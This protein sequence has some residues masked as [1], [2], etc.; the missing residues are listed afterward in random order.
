L[1]VKAIVIVVVASLALTA[2]CTVAEQATS[3]YPTSERTIGNTANPA[4][5]FIAVPTSTVTKPPPSAP[6]A[7]P[8]T[9]VI[10][11]RAQ[12]PRDVWEVFYDGFYSGCL[13]P[14][15]ESLKVVRTW[16][17]TSNDRLVFT[18]PRGTWFL[19]LVANPTESN[20]RFDSVIETGGSQYQSLN[21]TN[22]VPD[23]VTDA[24][25]W[26][27][28]GF[29]TIP[30]YVMHIEAIGLGWT[31]YLVSSQGTEPLLIQASDALGGY[32]G[33]CPPLPALEDLQV[34]QMWA[35]ND[36]VTGRSLEFMGSPPHYFLGVR[37]ESTAKDW[38]FRSVNIS[39][40]W[41]VSGPSV[42]SNSGEKMDFTA[43]CPSSLSPHHLDVEAGGGSWVV[44][45]IGVQ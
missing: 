23:D 26:C 41:R 29:G 3:V 8:T 35:S 39:G 18:P 32:Y 27:T 7:T 6:I 9:T 5:T 45:L 19:V 4:A 36:G 16:S 38:F 25:E 14:P 44:Y 37:F 20:W 10:K 15:F 22:E 24:Q 1:K 28:I 43:I 13:E 2:A 40:D 42:S 30:R 34:L 12:L 11:L 17:N 33:L 21:V 31:L